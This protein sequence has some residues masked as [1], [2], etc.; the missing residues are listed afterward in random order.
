MSIGERIRRL[1]RSLDLT[2]KEFGEKINLKPNS[3]ALIEGGRNTSD[4]TIFAICREFG[5]NEE[6]IRT[7]NG[8]MFIPAATSELDALAI[9]YPNMTHESY[10]FIEKL[11][12]LPKEHQDIIM[13]FFREVVHGFGDVAPGTLANQSSADELNIDA[14]V[15]SYREDL[16]LQKEAEA[17]SSASDGRSASVG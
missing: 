15:A 12:N 5:V 10:V 6:W 3:I 17:G 1:R 7:G 4:Q 13:G 8:E 11:V 2:Q 9:R 14:E 16:L